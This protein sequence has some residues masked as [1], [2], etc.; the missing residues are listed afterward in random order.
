[1]TGLARWFVV[2]VAIVHGLIHLLGVAKGFG[3]A[4]VAELNEPI[5]TTRGAIWLIA[6]VLLV[7]TG[8]L[9]A[10]RWRNWW[11]LG[12]IAIT[13]SQIVIITAWNDA[14]A[15]TAANAILL[16]AVAFGFAANGPAVARTRPDKRRSHA[17]SKTPKPA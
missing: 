6:S 4:D 7:A 11:A 12:A 17:D 16:L 13:V 3:W 8:V 2:A 14:W 1:M 5:S 10:V 9:L 15:G